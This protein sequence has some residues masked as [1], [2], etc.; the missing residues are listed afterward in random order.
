MQLDQ[1]TPLRFCSQAVREKQI[2]KDKDRDNERKNES[3]KSNHLN[4]HDM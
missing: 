1:Q 3:G 2:D 4:G